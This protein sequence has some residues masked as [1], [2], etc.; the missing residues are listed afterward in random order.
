MGSE[1]DLGED[2]VGDVSQHERMALNSLVHRVDV[3]YREEAL[4]DTSLRVI[5]CQAMGSP[6]R[7]GEPTM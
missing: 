6:P 3:R 2:H 5:E 1:G 4:S 7:S